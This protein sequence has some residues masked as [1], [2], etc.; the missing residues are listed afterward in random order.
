MYM[1]F[2]S[3]IV[4]VIFGLI[5]MLSANILGKAGE[6]GN[7]TLL[8]LDEKISPLRLFIG[9]MLLILGVWMLVNVFSYPQF[10]YINIIGVLAIFFGLLFM[11]FPHSL[12][13]LSN[14][15][16]TVLLSTDE[17]VLAIR[18]IVG[19]VLLIAGSYILYAAYYV[20]VR[21]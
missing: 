17:I 5:L 2:F 16:N 18:K 21:Q 13:V 6:V 11:V 14:I 19:I 15:F 10:W 7:K 8:V 3:G 20:A 1:L 9:A 12:E 4:A